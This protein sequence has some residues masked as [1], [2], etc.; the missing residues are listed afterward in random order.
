MGKFEVVPSKEIQTREWFAAHIDEFEYDIVESDYGFPDY[1][2]RDKEGNLIRAEAESTSSNFI[3]HH[4]DPE[5]CDMV[6]CWSHDVALPLPVFELSSGTVYAANEGA[7]APEFSHADKQAKSKK[8][9]AAMKKRMKEVVKDCPKEVKLFTDAM[10]EDL[11]A[12]CLWLDLMTEPRMKLFAAQH[13]LE[14][15]LRENGGESIL[16]A[17]GDLHP[18]DL[19]HRVCGNGNWDL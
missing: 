6:V 5:G 11:R 19:F 15:A 7:A 4:H 12:E 10:A 9:V 3:A 16:T 13:V 14:K 2:L 1:I 8:T 18:H 17:W